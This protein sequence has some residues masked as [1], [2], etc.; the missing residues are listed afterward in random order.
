[1]MESL[2]LKIGD[3]GNDVASLHEQLALNGIEISAE[4]S[5]RK[6]FG[7]STR[8]AVREFQKKNGIDPSCEVC[9]QTAK[10]LATTPNIAASTPSN[11]IRALT[12]NNDLGQQAASDRADL[13][14]PIVAPLRFG[15][16]A[17]EV[18]NLQTGLILIVEKQLLRIDSEAQKLYIEGLRQEQKGQIY[19]DFTVKAVSIFQEQSQLNPT[20]EVD[21]STADALNRVLQNLGM[22][23][24]IDIRGRLTD[25][26]EIGLS[27][28][29]ISLSEYDLDGTVQIA[30]SISGDDGSFGFKF[31][32]N[33]IL[34][35]GDDNTAPD[36]VFQIFDPNSTEQMVM[37]I[38]TIAG[39]RETS[40]PRLSESQQAPIVLMN[41]PSALILRIVAD[42]HQRP[43]TEFEQL[44]ARLSPFMR[45]INFA[46][47]KEDEAN[48]QISFLNK[49]SGVEK[50]KIEQLRDAFKQEREFDRVPAWAFFGLA[51]QNVSLSSVIS[52]PLD[53][54]V[55]VLKPLQ[56]SDDA[57]NL[58]SVANSLKQFAQEHGIKT[59]IINLKTS[60]GELLQPIL[61]S[62][63]KLN[64]F[65]DAYARHEG[66]IESFWQA[67]S[68]N[69][70]FQA[71][72][73]R[74]QLNLQL[75]QLTLNNRGLID[76]LQQKG[77]KNTRQ[78]VD[79]P[80]QD[81]EAL[82]LEHKTDI[83]GHIT[84]ENDLARAKIYA[85]ELQTLVELAFP[86][87]VIKKSIQQPD[88]KTF[89]NNN[90]KF[91]FTL[92]PVEAYLHEQGE[93]AFQGIE[94]PEVVKSQLR[95]M[96]RLYN[97]TANANDMNVL[98]E[99]NY[100]S[101]HQIAKLS[102]ED[103]SQSVAAK[104]SAENALVYHAKALAVSDA[105]AMVYQQLRDLAGSHSFSAAQNLKKDLLIAPDLSDGNVNPS[106]KINNRNRDA[107]FPGIPNWE[108]LFGSID[109]CECQHCK[110]VYSPAAYFVD[111]LHILLGQNKG[112]ARVEIF[113]RRPD[114]MYTK[115][116][117][118]HTE[119]LIPYI[120]L[121]NEVLE[122]YVAQNHVGDGD[123]QA[124]AKDSTN[125]T[126]SFTA[127]DL[128]ANPQ[129]PNQLAADDAKNAYK[130][131]KEATFPLNLP[132][133]MDLEVAR[134]FL[135]EQ[136]SSRFEVMKTFGNL[137][138]YATAAERLGISQREFEI[139]T[140]KQ[141]D[142]T[143]DATNVSVSDL[144]GKPKN[145]IGKT[146]GENTKVFLE[147]ASITYLDLIDL[148]KTRFLNP[149]FPINVYL[150]DLS[151]PDRTSWLTAHPNEKQL[152]L[153]VIELGGNP[154]APCDL[155][156]TQIKHLNGT[157]L[158]DEELSHFNRFIRLWKKLGCTIAELDGLLM[159][160]GATDLTPQVIQDLSS[161]W[162]VQQDLD[163]SL[164]RV[165]VLIGNIPT[166]G[167]DSLFAKLF[168]NKAILQIDDKF[169]LNISHELEKPELE[170]T[171]E[172]LQNHVPAILAA[173]QISEEDLNR[174]VGYIHLNLATDTLTLA[175]LSKI[176]RYVVFAKGLRF[177]IEELI[178][179]LDLVSQT[180]WV[181]V[182]VLVK[183][184]E[185]LEK[186]NRYGFKAADFAYIF[187]N[188]I[189]AGNILPPKG[190]IINQSAKVLRE[191][192]LK[193]RQE[194][195]PKDGIVTADFLKMELGILLD[196]EEVSKI[197]GILDGSNSQNKFTDLLTPKISDNY[198][199]ILQNYLTT[200][201]VNDLSSTTEIPE[202]FNKY[203]G[204]IEGKLLPILRETFIQQHLTA[205][206]KIEAALVSFFLRDATVLQTC[207]DMETDTP[208]H[209][210]AYVELYISIYKCLWFVGKLK[211]SPKELVYFQ[212]N[213]NFS[214]FNWNVFNFATWL[215]VADFVGLRDA[216]PVAEKGLLSVFETAKSG[217]D[218]AKAI[219]EVTAWNKA[220][221]GYFVSKLTATDFLNEVFLILL[222]K[223]IELS[224]QIGVSIEKLESWVSDV[225]TYE[226]ARDIKHT[227][228]TKYD[229]TAWI[230]VSTQVHNRLRS[231][232]RD[233]LVAFLL[234]KSEIK[235]L[236]LKDTNDLY[237]YFLIDVEM[238]SCML[239]SR[240]KQAIASVQ[241]FVQ[242]CLLN[243]ESL[244]DKPAFIVPPTAINAKQW[245]WMKNYR[246]WEANRKV[247]LYPEN[248]IEPELRDNKSPYFKELESELLQGEVTNESVEKAL[249]NYL[250]KLHDVAR[251]DICGTYEDNDGQELHIFGRT[252]NS[253]PQYFYRK[254]DLKSQVWTAWEKV[255]VDIQGNE[256]GDSA[257]VHLI[258]VV[259]NRR[260]YLF[261][262]IFTEKPD[263]DRIKQDKDTYQKLHDSWEIEVANFDKGQRRL[264]EQNKQGSEHIGNT[265]PDPHGRE[266]HEENNPW[267]YYEV[268]LAWSEYKNKNWSNKKVSQSFIRTPSNSSGVAPTYLYRFA[269]ILDTTLK[270][271]L[272][273]QVTY[274]LNMLFL[275]GEYQ[276]NCNGK[277]SVKN[278]KIPQNIEANSYKQFSFYQSLLLGKAFIY[279]IQ[280]DESNSFPLT[281]QNRNN[282]SLT[283]LSKSDGEYK[284]LFPADHNFAY[285]SSSKFIYQD[286]KRNYY[287]KPEFYVS[288]A[289]L[290]E[291]EKTIISPPKYDF[292]KPTKTI[293]RGDIV[294]F[295]TVDRFKQISSAEISQLVEK[296]QIDV[297]T[298][299][300]I[301]SIQ[302]LASSASVEMGTRSLSFP[303]T[304]VE[305]T[306]FSFHSSTTTKLQFK[307]FFHAYVCKFMESLEK[308]GIE[309]LLNLFNQQFSD[310]EVTYTSGGIGGGQIPT[311]AT[312]NFKGIYLPDKDNVDTPYPMEEVD[313]SPGGAYSLYNWELFFHVPML[314]ANRLSK[315]QRFEEA[316][317]WY[318]FIFN[319]TTNDSLSTSAR[320]WQVIPL[321]NTP[322]ET[323]E[324]LFEQ[325]KPASDPGRRRELEDA[326]TAW[327]NNPFSPHLIARMRLSAYQK[328]TVMKYLD[329]LISWG[330]SLFRQDTIESINEATQLYILAAELLGKRPEKI[331]ARGTIQ[332]LNY[333]ELEKGLDAFSNAQVKLETI[334]PFYNLQPVHP[335]VPGTAP[336]F[337][338][339]TLYFCLPDNDKLL[340]YWD[341][342]AD[343]LFKIRHCQNIE[344]IER[345]LALFEPPID[346]A[347]LVQAVA[348][349][350]D[351]SSVLA[352]LN[353]PLPHYRFDY[354]LNKALAIC[355]ELQSLGNSLLSA[356]EKKDGESLSMM[357]TQH[358][359][360]LLN[361]AKTVKK[362]QI[363]EAQLNRE[364]LEKTQEV[365]KTRF[366][367]Y[368]KLINIKLIEAEKENAKKLEVAKDRQD[369]AY[370]VELAANLAHLLPDFSIGFLPHPSLG[371]S[372]GG[373]YIGSAL[374]AWARSIN[375]VASGYTYEANR[376]STNASNERRLS[377]WIFQQSV[378]KKELAQID[379]QILSAQIREQI[380]EQELTNHEQSI[381]NAR[382][383]EDFYRNKF[384]QEELYGWMIGEISTIYFQCY[385]LAYDL[386][387]KAE[388]TYRY[389]LGLPT[390]NFVQFGIWDSFRKGLMS[391][392][393]LYLSLKQMEKSYMDQ[394][395]RE[396]EIVKHISLLQFNPFA[397]IALKETGT[398]LIELPEALF[399]ADYPGHYMRR[400]KSVSITIPCVVGP[401]TSINC[402]L[403]LLSSE[404]RIKSIPAS[405][406][407]KK[408]DGDDPRFITNYAAMQSIATST[409]QNDSGLF[410][411]NFRDERYLPFEGAGAVSFWRIDLPK[412]CN[413][414]DFDSISD[415]I[416]RLNYT[417]REGG[418][419]LKDKAKKAMSDAFKETEKTP[420][421]RLFSTKHEFPTEW[422]QFLHS[423]LPTATLELDLSL[424]RFPFQFRGKKLEIQKVELFLPL[425]EGKKPATTAPLTISLK[426]A[427]GTADEKA[428]TSSPSLNGIP[429]VMIEDNAVPNEVKSGEGAAWSL[430]VDATKLKQVQDA[431]ADLFIVCHYTVT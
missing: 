24:G 161:L 279:L 360:L 365:T 422:H 372:L 362:L 41:V 263:K 223:Q 343:R 416:L 386:A 239:T 40:V 412:D 139:L 90:P 58:E 215:Q 318:H 354:I 162:Q 426:S 176:Y 150:Q 133:D 202:R 169:T 91:D 249:I 134:Q 356:L 314:L 65:L 108:S 346:P 233:A 38:F 317:R 96:Q 144:W 216:L 402:T 398:S 232:L 378:A 229:E 376:S 391:G 11:P 253:P 82:A 368:S 140:L 418:K 155:S 375:Y 186:L 430:T 392:E 340:G 252:F 374:N 289:S 171:T 254:L 175:N 15:D 10:L 213:V 39:E 209:T 12:S 129:H 382:Q 70:D 33:E 190:E 102:V 301:R 421:S 152:T 350:V 325:L 183:T 107:V 332:A 77:I 166:A 97:L 131:L 337:S 333:G 431:I 43:L 164:D 189:V 258:P 290:Q 367:Y 62:E 208:I 1:M 251:L 204:K 63:A 79:I 5:K 393:R 7:P 341:T 197:I 273:Y 20:G 230:E 112:A 156:T 180:P 123:A 304:K 234:Q 245:E 130:R 87:D 246:V 182:L 219:I 68:Q 259:W 415:V 149:N 257:G 198:K 101:A 235:A 406:Y 269:L 414:F 98:M 137:A 225:V 136:S 167:K 51:S 339:T 59:Q 383:V 285:N 17:T 286:R 178:L 385:Q 21:R 335:G 287:V 122:I 302:T 27:K 405:P 282:S 310:L 199:N 250:E 336:I 163:L 45:Q 32:N 109:T 369:D 396:Y 380:A 244:K 47:L 320:Y 312:N 74:I 277:V 408:A 357:R 168:L 14:A 55:A 187:N 410:E 128:A 294:P 303:A 145:P 117:C 330:D 200:V 60:V 30:R 305:R 88:V 327:R 86:T 291:P 315:N 154:A 19:N 266:P 311:G 228:K 262:P 49:E 37:A 135:Q 227:L 419:T 22:S 355:S 361:L 319:P 265:A 211:L 280:W 52:M 73:P 57:L 423:A 297:S 185:L 194:N 256:E 143:S 89:L 394:N 359:T 206:F 344:G 292:D 106:P 313:F 44:V 308:D 403:T 207:L 278:E 124:H 118:E 121:V 120:D 174:I 66:E 61:A 210:D 104:I 64:V 31:N 160:I 28:Y 427:S 349:G 377:E 411:L 46:D 25:N 241:L 238:D 274:D 384:T 248:W 347:L 13:L 401:Y 53:E 132:F 8:D 364:G 351:I 261:W 56:P 420:L 316:M 138:S 119:T 93:Q 196:S 400:I 75:S 306:Y 222:Q 283:V 110:S 322:Q 247:F 413:A 363:T 113:R 148:L 298:S 260:L 192:L 165:A 334:F 92:T 115:L 217:G 425:K 114:L 188:E 153:K 242:R 177:K 358:E 371:F 9:N 214:N 429:H 84:G 221:V 388:K 193:I 205:T 255:S 224:R 407:N 80:A 6:F 331:P 172:F 272:L 191:G 147:Y 231:H 370:S 307:P 126:S 326:I 387:K 203:W 3:L 299:L 100:E 69:S 34:K 288:A 50:T 83:P 54:L 329:N 240:L 173:L 226:Q 23:S 85:Q 103:F 395:R 309:G 268:K 295:Q 270:I 293:D 158:S 220:N 243:L 2:R 284:L 404:T 352:D 201:D 348:G 26:H 18:V 195:T 72:V 141:L 409:A 99:M 424:E 78:L 276:L 353:S 373:S 321:R 267:A 151:E 366:D 390:S 179:W 67:M 76:A 35:Q 399:D 237:S 381:D 323:L 116:S 428:L 271:K 29:V 417:A 345:Q 184:K 159:A 127:P 16:R 4:E 142:G 275:Q 281:L 42:L 170:N 157:F 389:E 218:I 379:K 71:E 81:W 296:K 264:E 338:F 48:F 342:V 94:Q 105:S 328:N 236:E 125:D 36:L 95:P 146:L 324:K 181:S 111:L 300:Q 212:N 397:L